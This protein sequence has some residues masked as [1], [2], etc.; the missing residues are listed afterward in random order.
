MVKSYKYNCLNNYLLEY[1]DY[2][3]TVIKDIHLEKIRNWR[4]AQKEILRQNKNISKKEQILY[5][6]DNVFKDLNKKH[7]KNILLM[8]NYKDSIIGYGGLVH[9]SWENRRSE[10]SF[11]LNDNIK[12]GSKSFSNHFKSFLIIIHDLAFQKLNFIKLTTDAFYFRKNLIKNLEINGYKKISLNKKHYIKNNQ[13]VN[14]IT[15]AFFN[16]K[17]K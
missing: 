7:P 12:R 3:L 10:I 4:N 2:S 15:H 14:S 17:I 9:I 11:L 8:I 16:K 6:K 1:K 5:F 13:I